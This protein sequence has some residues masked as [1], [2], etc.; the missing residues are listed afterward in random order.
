[1]YGGKSD[2]FPSVWIEET[3]VSYF[4]ISNK[5]STSK[6][7]LKDEILKRLFS[8][9]ETK[10]FLFG[11]ENKTRSLIWVFQCNTLVFVKNIFLDFF[12]CTKIY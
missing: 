9:A 1:M 2:N 7:V 8:E 5:L 12:S 6:V 3:A 4:S 10:I 11:K